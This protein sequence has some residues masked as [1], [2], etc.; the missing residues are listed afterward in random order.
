MYWAKDLIFWLK[1][2]GWIIEAWAVLANHYHFVA[3]S[4]RGNAE[5]LSPLLRKL[6]SQA[7]QRL[8]REDGTPGRTRLWQNFF[9]K[10]VTDQR[11]YL[12]RLNYVHQNPKHHGLV[13]M[14]S[15]WKWCSADAFKRQVTPAW[16][17]TIASFKYDEIAKLDDDL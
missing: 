12:A 7:T 11:S 17:K 3:H 9:E 5:T 14:A 1:E 15:Q 2:N 10:H 16:L 13:P 4:P 8:N 6:H